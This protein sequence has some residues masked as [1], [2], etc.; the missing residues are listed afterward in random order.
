MTGKILGGMLSMGLLLFFLLVTISFHLYML[1][2]E[3]IRDICYDTAEIISTK[4]KLSTEVYDYFQDS[5]SRYGEFRIEMKLVRQT[6]QER[7]DVFFAPS[8]IVGTELSQGDLLTIVVVDVNPSLLERLTGSPVR[9]AAIQTAV[10][11]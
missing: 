4:G 6:E 2:Q 1:E 10:I 3:R 5:L 8:E 7:N 11:A 9:A